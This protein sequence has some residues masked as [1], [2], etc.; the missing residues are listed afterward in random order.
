M[1][2][3]C[4]GGLTKASH[5]VEGVDAW[6]MLRCKCHACAQARRAHHL[7]GAATRGASPHPFLGDGGH[8][9]EA[10]EPLP[11]ARAAPQV[12]RPLAVLAAALGLIFDVVHLHQHEGRDPPH[13]PACEGGHER[14][15]LAQLA[16]QVQKLDELGVRLAPEA[17]FHFQDGRDEASEQNDDC[18]AKRVEAVILSERL[19]R[20][21]GKQRE[22]GW[23]FAAVLLLEILL[24]DMPLTF[25]FLESFL[26]FQATNLLHQ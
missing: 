15:H 26:N 25:T 24:V 11:G 16:R 10:D 1:E 5:L 18:N 9:G 23:I 3:Y 7:A 2:I 21:G 14:I 20:Q 8:S 17:E 13:G 19:V 22:G 6:V 12:A 4:V